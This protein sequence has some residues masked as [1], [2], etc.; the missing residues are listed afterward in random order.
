MYVCTVNEEHSVCSVYVYHTLTLWSFCAIMVVL[1]WPIFTANQR[2]TGISRI[3]NAT[4]ARKANP[5]YN[6]I[7]TVHVHVLPADGCFQAQNSAVQGYWP[8]HE[9]V[10]LQ[11]HTFMYNAELHIFKLRKSIHIQTLLT[12]AVVNAQWQIHIQFWVDCLQ[13]GRIIYSNLGFL[14][15]ARSWFL[16]LLV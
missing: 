12:G 4:P 16:Y 10:H 6:E 8:H 7:C 3:Q 2:F 13:L 1:R 5:T 9:F 15:M 11:V 14:Y